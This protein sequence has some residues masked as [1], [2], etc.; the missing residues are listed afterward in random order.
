MC[1][2][3]QVSLHAEHSYGAPHMGVGWFW[4]IGADNASIDLPDAYLHQTSVHEK[5][6]CHV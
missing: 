4:H 1:H 3:C 2:G 5:P 6:P